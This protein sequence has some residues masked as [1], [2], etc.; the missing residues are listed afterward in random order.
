MAELGMIISS[1]ISGLFFILFFLLVYQT[2]RKNRTAYVLT[3]S[4]LFGGIGGIS[5]ALQYVISTPYSLL[6]HLSLILWSFVYFMIYIFFEKLYTN[7]PQR[8]RLVL[9]TIILF[10][11][12]IF[13][14]LNMFIPS[15]GELGL[16]GTALENYQ[17]FYLIIEWSWDI[18]YNLLGLVI[19]VFGAYVHL[20]SY[21]FTKD[22]I[23]LMQTISMCVLAVGFIIGFVGGD[24][25]DNTIFF[26]IGDGV[27]ILGMLIFTLIYAIFPDFIYRLP[28]NVYF[29]LI[30][31]KI[32]L[33]IHIGRIQG[34]IIDSNTAEEE[35]KKAI[36]ENLLSSLIS[37]ISSL[38]TESLGSK[39]DLKAIIAGDRS[40]I[41]DN[42]EYATCAI[43]SDNSTYFLEKSLN[44][45]RKSIETRYKEILMKPVI[46]KE[47]FQDAGKLI[48]KSFPFLKLE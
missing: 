38:L 23:I 45:L 34:T 24:I 44:N 42:G 22:K 32:G 11:S 26:D 4:L 35:E 21:K 9:I 36:S 16:T 29:I 28:V 25:I 1:V 40:L 39:K 7:R 46:I 5:S 18:S 17:Q 14:L 41:L 33:N 27:K 43:L 19:F 31:S 30:F 20:K 12:I 3:F 15:A 10:A 13:N 47:D 48:R 2:I 6:L 37:A 8:Y